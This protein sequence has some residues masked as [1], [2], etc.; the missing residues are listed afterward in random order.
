MTTTLTRPADRPVSDARDLPRR[1]RYSAEY[2]LRILEEADRCTKPGELGLLL[3]C[4]GRS[5]SDLLEPGPVV[6][7]A[8]GR[9]PRPPRVAEA[10]D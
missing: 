7:P 5:S 3:R 9:P 1:R 6:S 4:E 2:K 8:S 10:R